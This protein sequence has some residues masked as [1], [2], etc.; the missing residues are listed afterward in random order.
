LADTE[1]RKIKQL[2]FM[3]EEKI[4]TLHV[5]KGGVKEAVE[6]NVRQIKKVQELWEN[7][8]R[9]YLQESD[10]DQLMCLDFIETKE[11]VHSL[12]NN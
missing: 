12:L 1:T 11:E 3:V 9:L 7:G 6:V 4:I 2:A 5:L 8:T 10:S